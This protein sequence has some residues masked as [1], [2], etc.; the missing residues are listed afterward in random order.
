LVEWKREGATVESLEIDLVAQTQIPL[1]CLSVQSSIVSFLIDETAKIDALIEKKERLI[2]LLQ[3]KRTALITHVVT[4]GL[5]P[6]VPM[7]DSGI[8]WLG[9][10]PALW[11]VIALK[12]RL[13]SL[14]DGTHGTFERVSAGV[15][16]LS[17]KNVGSNGRLYVSDSESLISESDYEEISRNGYLKLGDLLL[18]IVGTIGRA[19]IFD[20][21]EPVA[22][23]RSVAALR[24][25]TRLSVR[26]LYYQTQA[27]FF[28]YALIQSSKQSAQGGVYLGNIAELRIVHP[29]VDEQCAIVAFIDKET[30]KT[31]ALIAKV[32][33]A[34]ERLKEFRT[35]L[36][37]AAVTGK[38][39]IREA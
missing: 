16:L 37:S 33:E 31:D 7:K 19:A 34:I 27:E 6:T 14:N 15:P 17:A 30:A 9:K 5:D 11:E 25:T 26:F 18:T 32:C 28:Q 36:I 29:S 3:E 23:Q 22:F 38:I 13:V 21:S 35:A 1:P 24:P 2:E 12:R 8:E 4:K 20:Y 10:I 39:D